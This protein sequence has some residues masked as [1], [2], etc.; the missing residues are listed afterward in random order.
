MEVFNCGTI[1]WASSWTDSKN[2]KVRDKLAS[3]HGFRVHRRTGPVRGV[4][5]HPSR[6]LLVT[7]G[8]DY[9]V[10]VWGEWIGNL[11]CNGHLC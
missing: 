1:V 5:F 8:D 7:G 9:K 10:K 4:N 2:T 11:K 6:A 3:R